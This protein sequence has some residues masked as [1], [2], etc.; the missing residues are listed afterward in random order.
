MECNI[1]FYNSRNETI[2]G[3][4][5]TP[6]LIRDNIGR[7]LII[8]PNCG[9][10]GCEGDFRSYVIMARKLVG[11]GYAVLR[12]SPSGLGYSD[13][14]ISDCRTKELFQKLESGLFV[15]EIKA[16]ISFAKS[17]YSYTSITLSGICGG[18]I[19]CFL[20]AAE[21]SEI[22]SII[23]ISIPVVLDRDDA[24]YNARLPADEAK[25]RI[26]TYSSK[27]LSIKAWLRLLSGKSDSA[28]I[29]AAITAIVKGKWGSYLDNG[30]KDSKFCTNPYFLKAAQKNIDAKKKMLFVFGE[31]DGFWWEF[32]KLYLDQ[33][34]GDD[35]P[36]PFDIYISPRSNHMLSMREMQDDVATSMISWLETKLGIAK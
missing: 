12:F 3:I 10:V 28:A 19:S 20:A 32:R 26:K 24:D 15:P 18:A 9:L 36:Y 21:L 25:L 6:E 23:P 30:G 5:H 29:T 33:H 34:Y 1:Q 2:R 22:E 17:A 31:N 35:Q 13:G 4:L 27:F 8:F 14:N 7:R 11:A 16:A